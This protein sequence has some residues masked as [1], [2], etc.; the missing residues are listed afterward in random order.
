M[1]PDKSSVTRLYQPVPKSANKNKQLLIKENIFFD[2]FATVI[3]E[4]TWKKKV[5]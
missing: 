4:H 1:S 5:A 3:E 2:L